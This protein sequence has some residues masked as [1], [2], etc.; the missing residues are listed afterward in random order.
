MLKEYLFVSC[1]IVAHSAEPNLE[2][3][4]ERVIAINRIVERT[5]HALPDAGIVWASGGD[6]GHVAFPVEV[7]CQ[8]AMDLLLDLRDWSERSA[9]QMRI[10]TNHGCAKC[11]KGADGRPQLVGPGINLAGRL[12]PFGGQSRIIATASVIESLSRNVL[13]RARFHD[14][15]LIQPKSFV[16]Q[17]IYLLSAEGRFTSEWGDTVAASDRA[18]LQIALKQDDGLEI[19]YR[20][21]RLLEVNTSDQ[22]AVSAL[23]VLA[24]KKIRLSNKDSFINDVFI[25]EQFGPE[26]IRTGTL[27]ER[28]AG[29]TLCEYN[30]DGETMFLILR[31]QVGVYL[32]GHDDASTQTPKLDF[33]MRSGELAGEIAF[34]LRR[35][36]TANLRCVEDTS[37]LAFSYEEILRP[38]GDSSRKRQL[39]DTLNRK[40]LS[41]IVENVWNTAPYFRDMADLE[42]AAPWLSL[43]HYCSLTPI[44]WNRREIR[45]AHPAFPGESLCILVSGRLA[46]TDGNRILE[47]VNYPIIFADLPDDM[48]GLSGAYKLLEDVK[49]LTIHADGLRQLGPVAYQEVI[50]RIGNFLGHSA[51]RIEAAEAKRPNRGPAMSKK[52]IFL[53]YCR[54]NATEVAR[55]RNDLIAAGESVWWDQDIKGGQDWKFE[56]RNAMKNAYAVVLCLSAESEKRS[57]SGIYPEALDA[58]S[59]YREYAPGSIFLIPVRLSD[60][61]IP[62]IELDGTRTLDRLQLID[63]F[64]A[65]KYA[66]GLQKLVQAI[67]D[68]PNHP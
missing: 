24:L 9:V 31:G 26:V 58:V 46:T 12:L 29:E 59:A 34:A 7:P 33:I 22:E 65:G 17:E 28:R 62:P 32:P 16:A 66:V 14:R 42:L 2:L 47:G 57:A 45:P 36:R 50:Q 1:D 40:I 55:L 8:F 39:E 53:S 48:E 3:Q 51:P 49:L 38:Y 64:P 35:K 37:V 52:H 20:A 30:D 6:G 41:R 56:I 5:L 63:L 67:G 27:I 54:D 21:R 68:A 19:I 15:R 44:A 61:E 11:T 43:L 10:S 60:C 18:S 25:D 23:R 13:P 4:T